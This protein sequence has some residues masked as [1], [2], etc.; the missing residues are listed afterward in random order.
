MYATVVVRLTGAL[1]GMIFFT[2]DR[3]EIEPVGRDGGGDRVIDENNCVGHRVGETAGCYG[4]CF[5]VTRCT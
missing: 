4:D 5:G 1:S 3:D 2:A